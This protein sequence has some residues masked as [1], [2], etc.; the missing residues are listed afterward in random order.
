MF[1]VQT[2]NKKYYFYIKVKNG[3][4]FKNLLRI[5]IGY[6]VLFGFGGILNDWIEV[7]IKRLK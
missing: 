2:Y 4:F 7:L 6:C 1:V 3:F 5:E